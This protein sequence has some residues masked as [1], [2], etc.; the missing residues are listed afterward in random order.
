V[1]FKSLGIEAS[2]EW[3]FHF[4]TISLTVIAEHILA[5]SLSNTT[6]APHPS[7]S[8]SCTFHVPGAAEYA[9]A[10]IPTQTSAKCRYPSPPLFTTNTFRPMAHPLVWPGKYF[11]YPIGNTSAVCLTRDLAPEEPAKILLLGCGDPRNVLYTIFCEPPNSKS[12]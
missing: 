5:S 9:S 2:L 8:A 3:S 4:Y 11:F 12:A 1:Y 6:T 7:S 10:Q